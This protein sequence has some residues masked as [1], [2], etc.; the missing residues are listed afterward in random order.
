[1]T[2]VKRRAKEHYMNGHEFEFCRVQLTALPSGALWW[3]GQGVLCVSDLHLGKSERMARRG[4]LHLPPYDVQD[5]LL[6]LEDDLSITRAACVIC[7]GDSFDD[8]GAASALPES[9]RLWIAR[10]QAGREWVWIEGNHDPGPL[11]LGGAHRSEFVCNGLTFR[12]IARPGACAEIS[13]H[14]HP[15]AQVRTRARWITRPA[16]LVDEA[17]I[18]MPA[19]GTYTGGLLS[20]DAALSGLMEPGAVAILT[21]QRAIAVPMPV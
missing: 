10:M 8:L 1:M 17:R 14:Y 9:A 13:G 19:Y 5:T 2:F 15:K 3:P 7:L 21:G 4:G 6:R 11:G 12:H 20:H 16:F 18:I